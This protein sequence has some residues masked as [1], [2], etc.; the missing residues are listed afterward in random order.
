MAVLASLSVAESATEIDAA[1]EKA[2]RR[3]P[4][5]GPDEWGDVASA[6]VSVFDVDPVPAE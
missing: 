1:Y 3:H 4:L 5:N 6:G 2:Y